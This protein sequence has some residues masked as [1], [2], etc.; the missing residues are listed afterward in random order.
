MDDE[1]EA[2]EEL[3]AQLLEKHCDEISKLGEGMARD[4]RIMQT[5]Q[6]DKFSKMKTP[7][8]LDMTMTDPEIPQSMLDNLAHDDY[9]LLGLY[10]STLGNNCCFPYLA[11]F[12]EIVLRSHSPIYQPFLVRPV[13]GIVDQCVLRFKGVKVGLDVDCHR[14]RP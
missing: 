10:M 9:K 14:L 1:E 11:V 12:R 3:A 5:R 13:T 7:P 6:H 2:N 4:L 8:R